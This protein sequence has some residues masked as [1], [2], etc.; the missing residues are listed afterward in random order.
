MVCKICG[1]EIFN[2]KRGLC[3]KCYAHNYYKENHISKKKEKPTHCSRCGR[4][5]KIIAKGLC[6]SCYSSSMREKHGKC[7]PKDGVCK[8]CG[9]VRSLVSYGRCNRCTQAE[10]VKA[11]PRKKVCKICGE[12]AVQLKLCATHLA[13]HKAMLAER[14]A[15]RRKEYY[16][17]NREAYNEK[18]KLHH[19]L[20]SEVYKKRAE[21]YTAKVKDT[22]EY[23]ERNKAYHKAWYQKHKDD[24]DYKLKISLNHQRWYQR[25]KGKQ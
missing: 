24:P 20:N 21:E 6:L 23:K 10:R 11:N 8:I 5:R 22:P 19:R 16:Q 7:I 14:A 17:A 4:E 2:K 18:S 15:K 9:E 13:E 12:E 25:K 1:G 3:K